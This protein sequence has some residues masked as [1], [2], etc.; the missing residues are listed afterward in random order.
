MDAKKGVALI[1]YGGM[2]GWHVD[3]L[4]KSDVAF[5]SGVWDIDPQRRQVALEKGLRAYQSLTELWEDEAA[6]IVVLAV[7]NDLHCSLAIQ[8][9]EAGKHVVCEKPVAMSSG[10]LEQMIAASKRTGRLFTVHQNRRWDKDYLIMKSIFQENRLGHVF[11]VE[12]RV[13][14]SHG[15]PG[16]WRSQKA[17]GGGMMLDWGVHLID[18]LL[19]MI[20]G[21]ITSLYCKMDHVT[22]GECDDGFRLDLYFENNVHA[23]V[24]VGTNNFINLPRWYM[25]GIDGTAVIEDWSR[26]GK[27]VTCHIRKDDKVVPVQTSAGL[28]KTMAPRSAETIREEPLPPVSSDVHDFYRNL[29]RAIDGLE[30][31]LVTHDQVLRVFRLMEAAFRSHELGQAV[32][33]E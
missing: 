16:D 28:T 11:N 18:Q 20:P 31:Q 21:K 5:L 19:M 26:K 13:Q 6:Q 22:N 27:I 9:M 23:Y 33:F 32:S 1:G 15:I 12:S 25:Q 14:G 7:P 24:E 30:T 4:L 8:A 3:H 10:E 17:H 29:C 2:G